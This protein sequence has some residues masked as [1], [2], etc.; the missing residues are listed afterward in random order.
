MKKIVLV[1]LGISM[2]MSMVFGATKKSKE[3]S[4][5]EQGQ[6]ACFL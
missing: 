5:T 3:N 6:A 2:S 1:I 4:C